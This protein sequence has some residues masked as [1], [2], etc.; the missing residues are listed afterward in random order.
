MYVEFETIKKV[1]FIWKRYLA[2]MPRFCQDVAMFEVCVMVISL[3]HTEALVANKAEKFRKKEKM[4]KLNIKN[5]FKVDANSTFLKLLVLNI[6][7]GTTRSINI[8]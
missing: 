1:L 3:R 2:E 7:E 4:L 6:L 5:N 8:L